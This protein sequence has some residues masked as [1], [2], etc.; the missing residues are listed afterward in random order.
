MERKASADGRHQKAR[1]IP[2]CRDE[3]IS[4]LNEAGGAWTELLAARPAYEGLNV[5]SR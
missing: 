2:T 5:S 4:I 1:S 3:G